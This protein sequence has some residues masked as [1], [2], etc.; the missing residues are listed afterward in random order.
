MGAKLGGKA[1]YIWVNTICRP[2]DD[3]TVMSM[4]L[5]IQRF[6]DCRGWWAAFFDEGSV[7]Q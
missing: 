2:P 4:I 1:I 7:Q 5:A 3:L 6:Y